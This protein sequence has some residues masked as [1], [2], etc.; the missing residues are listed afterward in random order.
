MSEVFHRKGTSVILPILLILA[1][2]G[3][4]WSY[5]S[6]TKA[7]KQLSALTDP[8]IR[9]ELNQEQTKALLAKIGQLLVLP[10]NE[11][12]VVATIQDV[13][14]LASTQDFYKDAEN[15]QKL[16]VYSAAR[17]A[18]IY[19]EAK[20]KLVN[21]G[22]L[23][24]TNAEGQAAPI[25]VDG[26]ITL[27]IRNGSNQKDKGIV[28]RDQLASEAAFLIQN[29]GKAA[30][31]NYGATVVV[32]LSGGAKSEQVKKLTDILG[33]ATTDKLPEGERPTSAEV[34]VI[35]GN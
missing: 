23:V 8:N 5:F 6:Y 28:I 10:Q 30:N 18:I 1:L 12:P 14:V 35:V 32:D 11:E 9:N 27:D 22:P 19:D 16:V 3:F 25:R 24:V 33:V 7:Q 34:V 31:T 26:R 29:L 15:G 20:N 13:E 21:V 2:G 17:K 4:A